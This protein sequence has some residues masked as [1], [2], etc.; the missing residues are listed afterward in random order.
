MGEKERLY[1]RNTERGSVNRSEGR[2][3]PCARQ[4]FCRYW[5]ILRKLWSAQRLIHRMPL[6][7]ERKMC[8]A[9]P[10]RHPPGN[11]LRIR[12]RL[13]FFVTY[14]K[15]PADA[16]QAAGPAVETPAWD[17]SSRLPWGETGGCRPRR[18]A[19]LGGWGDGPLLATSEAAGTGVVEIGHTPPPVYLR[20][21]TD[22]AGGTHDFVAW[23]ARRGRWLSCSV[24]MVIAEAIHQHAL[25]VPVSAWTAAVEA[26]G[27]IR[28]RDRTARGHRPS[29]HP[30]PGPELALVLALA[31]ALDRSHH[32]GPRPARPTTRPSLTS[33]FPVPSTAH[34]H[35]EQWNPAP[36]RGD[37]RVFGL[38]GLSPRHKNGPPTPSADRHETSRSEP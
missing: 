16:A 26:D 38:H 25:K 24:G 20:I 34:P 2:G 23:L 18:H 35:P 7:P 1:D 17:I 28:H 8:R 37:T 22:S 3:P 9:E 21:R 36:S 27:E 12:S 6:R 19:Y 13:T 10:G 32:R 31:L 5:V 29:A 15:R 11:A 30:P 4:S 14:E 33:G